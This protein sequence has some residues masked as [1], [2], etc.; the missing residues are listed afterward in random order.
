MSAFGIACMCARERE[1]EREREV[2]NICSG[3]LKGD[4][5]SLC[6]DKNTGAHSEKMVL[7]HFKSAADQQFLL[8]AHTSLRL[9]THLLEVRGTELSGWQTGA[10]AELPP[11]TCDCF[12]RTTA[13]VWSV[14][15]HEVKNAKYER[16]SP[17]S[18]KYNPE[19]SSPA[20]PAASWENKVMSCS[21][22]PVNICN[23]SSLLSEKQHDQANL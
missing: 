16:L 17:C 21:S 5:R 11:F 3:C 1:R 22:L 20:H 15:G 19:G 23:V 10:S 14:R 6:R 9:Q 18:E 13:P 12:I 8:W 4:S 7:M 2:K